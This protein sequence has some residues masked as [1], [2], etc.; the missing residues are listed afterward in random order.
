MSNQFEIW[1]AGAP[2]CFTAVVLWGSSDAPQSIE[3]IP[4]TLLP[5][6]GVEH[7]VSVDRSATWRKLTAELSQALSERTTNPVNLLMV[8]GSIRDVP[9]APWQIL[10][11]GDWG[12]NAF[13]V[14]STTPRPSASGWHYIEVEPLDQIYGT[15]SGLADTVIR[16]SY[17]GIPAFIRSEC[18][19]EPEATTEALMLR[20]HFGRELRRWLSLPQEQFQGDYV[21]VAQFVDPSQE[22]NC[23]VA[24][25]PLRN[26]RR[27]A[28]VTYRIEAAASALRKAL[29]NEGDQLLAPWGLRNAKLLTTAEFA[30]SSFAAPEAL[31][32][33]HVRVH[34][35][36]HE[37][38]SVCAKN[39]PAA[40]PAPL[41]L[42]LLGAPI[43]TD[44]YG[45]PARIVVPYVLDDLTIKH[46]LPQT[47][48]SFIIELKN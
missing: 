23:P 2:N 27:E 21:I 38:V 33:P 12:P 26:R 14:Q 18:Y 46:Q 5:N 10:G 44:S 42:L 35:N 22:L 32:L 37:W 11:I 45:S 19:Y 9:G 28:G 24:A 39:A 29:Q 36:A 6:A 1:A 3:Y 40:N 4:I 48:P 8:D 16:G 34:N 43:C 17:E 15:Q 25:L 30:Q 31:K 20:E 7:L 41:D 13:R 47:T